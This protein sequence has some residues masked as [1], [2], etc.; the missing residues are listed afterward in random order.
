[1][2]DTYVNNIKLIN[3]FIKDLIEIYNYKEKEYNF[4]QKYETIKDVNIKNQKFTLLS[5]YN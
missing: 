2:D 3:N 4:M 1:M 5:I